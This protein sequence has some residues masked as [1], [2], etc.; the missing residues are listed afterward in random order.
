M[1]GVRPERSATIA[2]PA[3]AGFLLPPLARFRSALAGGPPFL[4]RAHSGR[5]DAS[6]GDA[7]PW[8]K[9]AVNMTASDER[10]LWTRREI[11]EHLRVTERYIDMLRKAG[12]LPCIRLGNGVRFRG[13]DVAALIEDP[14]RA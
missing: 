9:E 6:S 2:E 12:R 1:G 14:R 5:C 11:S 7:P 3:S 8:P 4:T 13:A 10:R